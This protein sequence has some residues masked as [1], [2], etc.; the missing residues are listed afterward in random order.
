MLFDT[1]EPLHH[2][3]LLQAR[4][5]A[6][7]SM[8][9]AQNS[10][11]ER[12]R[13]ERDTFRAERDTANAEVEKLQLLIKQLTRSRYGAHSEKIDPDQLQLGLEEVEQSLGAARAVVEVEPPD[14]QKATVERKP[15]QRNRGALPPHLAR[16]ETV[17][18]VEDKRCPCCG[19]VMHVIGEDV[20][21]MLDVV[22]ALYRVKVIRRPRYGCRSCEGAVVQAPA[23]E[24][25]LTGGIATE[26]VLAQVLV[27][28]YS[29]HLPLYRQ[30]QI[31]ARHGIDLD[32]STLANWVGRACWWLRPLAE[33]LLGSILS[34]PKIFADDTPVPVLDPGRGRTKTGRLWSYARDDRPWQGPLPPAVAYVYSENRQGV[35]PQSH[36]AEFTGVLQVD[37]YAG[38]NR[39]GSVELAFCWAHVRRK[40]FDFHHATGSPIAAEALRRIAE[41][42]Q[43]EARIRGRS[44]DDRARV[45]QAGSTPLVDAMKTWL[46]QELG[47][48]S[49]KSNLAEAI[50]Y[51]LRH[52]KGL[53]L[54]LKD[55]RVEIDFEY[56]RAHHPADQAGRQ[57]PSLRRF[58]WRGRKLGGYCLADPDG[59]AQ[60]CRA[61]RL[62]ARCPRTHRLGQNQSQPAELFAALGLEAFT[63]CHRRQ[64]LTPVLRSLRLRISSETA[65]KEI[66]LCD[67]GAVSSWS[68]ILV[69]TPAARGRHV[70][71][72]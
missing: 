7:M 16:V 25:P 68:K 53:G 14:D 34:S 67:P 15:P 59:K 26:A 4:L 44:P 38:F 3:V 71:R 19:G 39:V 22:P 41:L 11:V 5:T 61:V 30:A 33:L 72:L 70:V 8:L 64:Y 20:S 55:G 13:V 24:R 23:P 43:I 56:R 9:E 29:D 51:A 63:S 57:E 48:V 36:L 31:F 69:L 17:V 37:G 6:L 32:R 21:E 35:H 12:L 65:I 54:F 47:R 28:K 1:A 50:R 10:A 46:E 2:P 27:A 42:Y 62:S 45:R 18:D 66:A 58:G 60:R 52:W 40:F 49:A